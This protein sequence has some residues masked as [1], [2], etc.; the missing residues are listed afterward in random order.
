MARHHTYITRFRCPKCKRAGTAQWEEAER[1]A[2]PHGS[3]IS[4]L[5]S[6]SSGFRTGPQNGIFCATCA[7]Q[8]V[9]GHG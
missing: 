3:Q 4:S 8:V 2:L 1:I 6:L 9:S 7:V 5:K